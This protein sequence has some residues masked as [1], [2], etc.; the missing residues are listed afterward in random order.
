M[1]VEIAFFLSL[2]AFVV[3]DRFEIRKEIKKRENGFTKIERKDIRWS[4][5]FEKFV[6]F[7]WKYNCVYGTAVF[8]YTR[9]HRIEILFL[10]QKKKKFIYYCG[11]TIRRYKNDVFFHAIF[12]SKTEWNPPT[13]LDRKIIN[14]REVN[15]K[16]L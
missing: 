15:Q 10:E 6:L 8:Q 9:A 5:T 11:M 3:V 2:F 16:I 13:G 7:R 14:K 12:T 4:E 1:H